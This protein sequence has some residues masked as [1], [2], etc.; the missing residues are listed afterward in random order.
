[1]F[2]TPSPLP[3]GVELGAWKIDVVEI[4]FCTE[5]AKYIQF[6]T[7]RCQKYASNQK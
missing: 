4:L 2:I 3:T 1:M 5:T 6:R 7:L